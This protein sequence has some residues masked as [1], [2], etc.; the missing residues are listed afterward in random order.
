MKNE[1]RTKRPKMKLKPLIISAPF[2]NWFTHPDATSTLGT[3]TLQ[4]RGGPVKRAWRIAKTLRYRP[5][6]KGWS[7]KLGLPNEGIA[8][9][10]SLKKRE[11]A[12]KI[13]SLHGFATE[14][15]EAI[16][17]SIKYLAIP[18]V[19]LNCSCPNVQDSSLHWPTIFKNAVGVLNCST[20][21]VKLPP[22][23]WLDLV[24][25]AYDSGI[26]HFHAC[27]TLPV[28]CGGLSGKTLKQYSLWV[29]E[30]IRKTFPQATIIGGGGVYDGNEVKDYYAAG[31]N[32]IAIASCLLNPFTRKLR[33]EDLAFQA[34]YYQ[35]RIMK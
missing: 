28:P 16:F 1:Q 24:R 10:I 35:A 15:W 18:F 19:E 25:P 33:L 23:R 22:I 12:D 31:A 20:I 14:D 8:R 11:Y 34:D 5:A 27:N 9:L 6:L 7:N 4:Y 32:H 29:V 2:G 26:T 17:S 3:F 13:V 30:E 21:I